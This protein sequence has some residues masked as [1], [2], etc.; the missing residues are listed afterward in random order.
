[1]D[2]EFESFDDYVEAADAFFTKRFR[3]DSAFRASMTSIAGDSEHDGSSFK[4]SPRFSIGH[5][6]ETNAKVKVGCAMDLAGCE[7]YQRVAVDQSGTIRAKVDVEGN[8]GDDG[9]SLAA[10]ATLAINT[11][12]PPTEDSFEMEASLDRDD[13][14]A[15]LGIAKQSSGEGFATVSAGLK[16]F[17]GTVGVAHERS[18]SAG[19]SNTTAGFGFSGENYGVACLMRHAASQIDGASLVVLRRERRV[20]FAS[21]FDV[22]PSE[23][24]PVSITLGAEQAL[25]LRLPFRETMS[26]FIVGFKA[27]TAGLLVGKIETVLQKVRY[28]ATGKFSPGQTPLFGLNVRFES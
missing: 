5:D 11:V 6:G 23:E 16:A 18:L 20:I 8:G 4:F 3:E 2:F 10:S 17:N 9:P 1:M 21:K 14:Y 12:A 25:R 22:S 26:R 24:K 13:G 27:D 19:D 15:K 28:T 7:L